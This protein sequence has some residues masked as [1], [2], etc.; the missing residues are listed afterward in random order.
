MKNFSHVIFASPVWN[1]P[2]LLF[3]SLFYRLMRKVLV[4]LSGKHKHLMHNKHNFPDTRSKQK[5]EEESRAREK[6]QVMGSRISEEQNRPSSWYHNVCD[7]LI[8]KHT[9]NC[10]LRSKENR[11]L[12][13]LSPRCWEN[14]LNIPKATSRWKKVRESWC[15]RFWCWIQMWTRGISSRD[16]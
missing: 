12:R 14:F 3:A 1:L 6:W 10:L 5:W 4:S 15:E 11:F 16:G 13:C 9:W 8:R 7:E 2:S